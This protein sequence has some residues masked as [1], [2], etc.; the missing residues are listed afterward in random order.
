MVRSVQQFFDGFSLS[1]KMLLVV[2]VALTVLAAPLI[3]YDLAIKRQEIESMAERHAKAALDMLE[4]VHIQ[5]QIHHARAEDSDVA[6]EVL[7]DSLERFSEFNENVNLWLVMGPK[8]LDYQKSARKDV[9]RRPLDEVDAAVIE[10]GRPM[11]A[12]NA[13]DVL[14][15]TRPAV[16]GRGHAG[17]GRC[18]RCHSELM[19]MSTDEVI[20][21]YS[22]A[23]DLGLELAA[24]RR[25]IFVD[26]AV[27][28]L[29]VAITLAVIFSLLKAAALRPLRQLTA[30]TRQLASGDAAVEITCKDRIDELGMMA[31]SLDVFRAN[32]IEK[33]ALEREQEET[34]GL[35]ATQKDRLEASLDKERELNGLQR[36]FVSMVSHEFRTPLAIIDGNA[37]RI[38]KRRREITPERLDNGINKIRTSVVR[39]INLMESVL[40]VSRFEAGNIKFEPRLS[41]LGEVIEEVCTNHREVSPSHDVIA[42]VAKLPQQLYLDVNLMRQVVSNLIS[43]AIKYSPEGTR[44]WV[45]GYE[46]ADGDISISVRDEGPGIPS[47][48]LDKLFDRFFR[49]SVSTGIIGTGIGLHIVQVFIDLHGGR[50]D[51]ASTEGQGTTFTVILPPSGSLVAHQTTPP[52]HSESERCGSLSTAS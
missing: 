29:V 17:E 30:I 10:T 7:N 23:V 2:A 43:N 11:L 36:Q 14:R 19:G 6:S 22:A 51:V 8:V 26:I 24:W 25:G 13:D 3:I 48:E 4:A 28:A 37:Q 45:D 40:S 47:A 49:G 21:A 27:A 33:Q 16:L 52:A 42:D 31:R 39:L 32:L 15:V 5:P 18:V 35:L 46:A 9:L 41:D 34:L 44:I 12:L 50:V 38:E 1:S 20:G